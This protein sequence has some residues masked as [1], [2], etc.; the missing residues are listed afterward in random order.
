LARSLRASALLYGGLNPYHSYAGG[1]Y[2]YGLGLHGDTVTNSLRRSGLLGHPYAGAYAGYGAGYGGLYGGYGYP[3]YGGLYGGYG[4]N[5]YPYARYNPYV[6][7][8]VA[9]E[10]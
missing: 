8:T 7:S 6:R 4:Y 1:L 5:G 2:G 3:G 9:K 10:E